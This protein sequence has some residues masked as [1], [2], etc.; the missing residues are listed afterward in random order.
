MVESS[1]LENRRGG[2]LTVGSN[3]TLSAIF[4]SVT[5]PLSA[6]YSLLYFFVPL[7]GYVEA[8]QA[9][10]SSNNAGTAVH[11][12]VLGVSDG[13]SGASIKLDRFFCSFVVIVW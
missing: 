1:G 2:N 6:F 3:P 8:G 7:L 9:R 13:V 5:N 10:G 4:Q 11:P 12:T